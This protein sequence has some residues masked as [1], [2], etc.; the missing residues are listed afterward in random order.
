MLT[1]SLRHAVRELNCG[2]AILVLLEPLT[3]EVPGK[4]AL[5]EWLPASHDLKAQGG[6]KEEYHLQNV[7]EM[8]EPAMVHIKGH[9]SKDGVQ[10]Q[11]KPVVRIGQVTWL[12][13]RSHRSSYTR[14]PMSH[15]SDGTR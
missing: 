13:D 8:R 12:E 10:K 3:W 1:A 9:R 15:H 2:S 6:G 7:L 14:A 4:G 5:V 11:W